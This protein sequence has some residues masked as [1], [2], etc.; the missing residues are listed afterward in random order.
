VNFHTTDKLIDL[1]S[2][3]VK[4]EALTKTKSYVPIYLRDEGVIDSETIPNYDDLKERVKASATKTAK[5][6]VED[7]ND[8]LEFEKQLS[9]KK[10]KTP[11]RSKG[12][13][14]QVDKLQF[15][16]YNSNSC[17][18]D[19]FLH[20]FVHKIYGEVN[21][22]YDRFSSIIN[23]FDYDYLEDTTKALKLKE[24]AKRDEFREY[25]HR[26]WLPNTN[27]E[28]EISVVLLCTKFLDNELF[29]VIFKENKK[30]RSCNYNEDNIFNFARIDITPNDDEEFENKFLSWT[31]YNDVY[32]INGCS[33]IRVKG[34]VTGYSAPTV[35]VTTEI[36]TEPLFLLFIFEQNNTKLNE[37]F[38]VK[39]NI[40][41][42]SGNIYHL[43][44]T[45]NHQGR[46]FTSLI[47]NPIFDDD[48]K[49][50]GY[51]QY[52]DISNNGKM[53]KLADTV[54][55]DK[56]IKSKGLYILIYQGNKSFI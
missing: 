56:N 9:T 20:V 36:I 39:E 10:K 53:E 15:L 5:R 34:S 23:K 48:T 50:E 28:D 41:L 29:S 7:N 38:I 46:H 12:K 19:S 3:G 43:A 27:L 11:A 37:K 42:P 31:N 45:I 17:A 52:N 32:C 51:Y 8:D 30:C 49:P 26:K 21:G 40:S 33:E 44:A 14:K 18:Y 16:Q 4:Y 13:K 35:G 2:G 47:R 24:F 55:I 6:K 1:E 54:N 22:S 25:V